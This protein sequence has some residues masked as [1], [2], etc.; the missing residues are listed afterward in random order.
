MASKHHAT[1]LY[2]AVAETWF[3]HF[4]HAS[5]IFAKLKRFRTEKARAK[6]R[7]L[8]RGWIKGSETALKR[9][10]G[11]S[12]TN[13]ILNK[14]QI[15]DYLHRWASEAKFLHKLDVCHSKA[16]LRFRKI[17]A[18]RA[19]R[20]FNQIAQALIFERE[21]IEQTEAFADRKLMMKAFAVLYRYKE[22]NVEKS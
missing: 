5:T 9:V 3:S 11:A 22:E 4:K 14:L 1:Y 19:L 20:H 18:A 15:R 6:K 8:L 16:I 10:R 21:K 13:R 12:R 17:R 7:E 2:K